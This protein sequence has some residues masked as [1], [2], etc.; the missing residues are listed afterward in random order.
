[1]R[2][3][4]FLKIL[5]AAPAIAATVDVEQLLWEPKPM[6]TV[7]EMPAP[8][9][10][11]GHEFSFTLEEFTE[12]HLRPS[13]VELARRI[14]ADIAQQM[15]IHKD[16]F[17]F[18]TTDVPLPEFQRRYNFLNTQLAESYALAPKP[19]FFMRDQA[20]GISMRYVTQYDIQRETVR[21]DLLIGHKA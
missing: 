21:Y 1:M 16:A 7:P 4:D 3:R 17:V 10:F 14:D 13:I 2:R 15:G 5:L 6:V 18:A 8:M 11:D 12:E 9:R 20:T 19:P